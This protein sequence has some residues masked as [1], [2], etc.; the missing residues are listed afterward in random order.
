VEKSLTFD[1]L[2]GGKEEYAF[3]R[4][5]KTVRNG[6][7]KKRDLKLWSLLYTG[8]VKVRQSCPCV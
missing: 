3:R 7:T 1:R 5:R 6:K 8:K 4:V 2:G